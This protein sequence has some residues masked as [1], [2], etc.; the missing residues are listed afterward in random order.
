M[1]SISNMIC[2]IAIAVG[3]G[4]SICNSSPTSS[5]MRV[6]HATQDMQM[7]ILEDLGM[8][9]VPDVDRAN[10]TVPEDVMK[11]YRSCLKNKELKEKTWHADTHNTMQQVKAFP[12]KFGKLII[13]I[14]II[15]SIIVLSY[16]SSWSIS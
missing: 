4:I 12:L 7:K 1:Y 16:R 10:I 3:A 11:L 9:A 14:S 15:F 8:D 5:G 2:Y 6:E 13:T